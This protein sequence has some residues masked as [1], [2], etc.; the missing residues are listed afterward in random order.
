MYWLNYLDRNAIALAKLD[1]IDKD[2]NLTATRMSSVFEAEFL[3]RA[4]ADFRLVEYSTCVSIL[5][6]GYISRQL[7]L[8]VKHR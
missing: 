6:V 7:F 4:W 1:N 8:E 5:F 2:L 3:I